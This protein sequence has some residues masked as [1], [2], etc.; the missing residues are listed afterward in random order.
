MKSCVIPGSFDPFTLGHFDI[1]KRA[2]KLFDKVYVVIMTN[3]EK[4]GTFNFKERKLIASASCAE[5]QNVEVITADGLLVDVCSALKA[6]A[7]VKGLRSAADA[8]YEIPMVSMNRFI[9]GNDIE[10][11]FL[12]S[13]PEYSF[14]SSTF[15]R[16]LIKYNKP[17]IGAMHHDAI[18]LMNIGFKENK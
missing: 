14:I 2:A 5:L 6:S 16:E 10:T 11:V 18:K 12:S 15:V 13:R 7:I 8:E 4:K 1:V 3:S 17:L 9:G